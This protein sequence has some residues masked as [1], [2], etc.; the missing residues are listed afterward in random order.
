MSREAHMTIHEVFEFSQD[1]TDFWPSKQFQADL[2]TAFCPFIIMFVGNSRAGKSTRLNQ[3]VL[4]KLHS[5][6]PFKAARGLDPVT[7]KFQYVGP[8]KFGELSHIHGIDLEVNSNPDIFLVDC[9]GLYSLGTTTKVVE[10]ATFAL[11]QMV[12]MTVLLMR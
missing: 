3:L 6:A 9:E 8:L 1:E 2:T 12:S 10:Q 4:R 11:S 7:M 5:N